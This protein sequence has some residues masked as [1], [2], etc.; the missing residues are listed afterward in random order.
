[1]KE[2]LDLQYGMFT[3][4]PDTRSIWFNSAMNDMYS[5]DDYVMYDMIGVICGLAIYNRVILFLPFPLTLY[6]KLLDEPLKLEDLGSLDPL[7][8]KNLRSII[9]TQYDEEEFNAIYADINFV[10]LVK[11]FDTMVEEE[12]CHG[13]KEKFLTYNN[14]KEYVDL[15]WNYILNVSIDKQ[16]RAFKNGF[17]K[18]VDGEVL[19][20]F[21]AEELLQLI[22]GMQDY[23]WELLE[24]GAVY[25]EPFCPSHSTIERFWRV[26]HSLSLEEKKKF[27]LFLTGSDRIPIIGM[28]HVEVSFFGSLYSIGSNS[29]LFL[30]RSESSP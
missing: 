13:G 30:I 14:R 11:K 6:K 1:M 16:F 25:K 4:Y 10:L 22:I 17:M 7:L 5:T 26:F 18:V 20:L 2:A 19:K 9:E 12:L 29:F 21:N 23:D 28:K 3:E 24:K 8:L 15:Y 27:L